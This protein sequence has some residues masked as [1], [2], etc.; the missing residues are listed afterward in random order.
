VGLD[1]G[2]LPAG[3][4]AVEDGGSC[5]AGPPAVAP[6]DHGLR[7]IEHF[8]PLGRQ[9]EWEDTPPGRPQ[10]PPYQWWRPHDSYA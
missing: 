3:A 1:V 5:V 9:A 10:T 2:D 7:A 8:T 6:A 4:V